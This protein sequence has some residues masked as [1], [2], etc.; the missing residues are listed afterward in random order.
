[1]QCIA[2]CWI[3]H[4]GLQGIPKWDKHKSLSNDSSSIKSS[5]AMIAMLMLTRMMIRGITTESLIWRSVTDVWETGETTQGFRPHHSRDPRKVTLITVILIFFEGMTVW[6]FKSVKVWKFEMFP[7][8]L[9]PIPFQPIPPSSTSFLKIW[10]FESAKGYLPHHSCP[11][12]G[13][14][15][16]KPLSPSSSSRQSTQTNRGFTIH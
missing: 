3:E 12:K 8:P 10:E 15:N 11:K 5:P 14:T 6:K 13:H 2:R 16:C 9:Q 4:I 1:M 7:P